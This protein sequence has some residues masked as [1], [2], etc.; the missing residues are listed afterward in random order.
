MIQKPAKRGSYAKFTPE[1]K[2]AMRKR[3]AEHDVASTNFPLL[4]KKQMCNYL[5]VGVAI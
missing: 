4:Q 2:A 3:A 1:Q 5:E